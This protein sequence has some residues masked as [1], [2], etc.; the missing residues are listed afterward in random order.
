MLAG[1][2]HAQSLPDY[3]PKDYSKLVEASKKET[4]LLI[5]SN[6]GPA[7]W[8]PMLTAFNK[9]YPWVQVQTLD[10]SS[11]EVMERYLAEKATGS[12]TADLLVTAAADAWLKMIDRKEITN[13]ASPEA[14]KYPQW[15]IPSPGLYTVATDP[16]I[17]LWNKQLVPENLRPKTFADMVKFAKENPNIFKGKITTYGAHMDS[18]GYTTAWAFQ[19]HHGQKSWDWW[20]VIGP[21]TRPERSAGPMIEKITTGEYAMGYFLGARTTLVLRNDPARAA[22]LGWAF[23]RDGNPVMM[24][25]LA[26]PKA[27]TNVNSAKLMLDFLLSHDGQVSVGQGGFVPL[28]PDVKQEEV[29]LNTYESVLKE[30]GSENAIL[31][32]YV[33]KWR[34][35]HGLQ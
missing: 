6:M 30:I 27:S 2:G 12:R 9:P 29:P 31:I 26:V 18:F 14:S 33:K 34:A 20:Q 35:A 15:S 11:S 5:Y 3:Y 19:K 32:T 1:T 4:P 7:Q 25:G 23:I 10:L 28:R 22:I 16:L 17:F 21:M 8:K 24:R 13:Y